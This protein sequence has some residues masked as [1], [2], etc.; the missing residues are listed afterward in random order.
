M[1]TATVE[2]VGTSPLSFT[3]STGAQ[4]FVPLSALEFECSKIKLRS[5]WAGSFDA[6]EAMRLLAVAAM[7]RRGRRAHAA[8][9]PAAC[10]PADGIPARRRDEQH[11]R[12]RHPGRRPLTAT[13]TVNAV[14]VDSYH[15]LDSA[16]TAAKTIG[17][18]VSLG[19]QN[20]PPAGTGVV[21]IKASP[22]SAP[23]ALPADNQTGVL[24]NAGFEVR[25]RPTP[26]C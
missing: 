25:T 16:A 19:T 8:A 22:V 12:H 7:P 23:K 1:T 26:L 5:G 11:H 9:D 15:G 13:M 21:A 4:Q 17:V 10:D 3:D 20:T 24:T 2:V 18:D 6:A 14:E